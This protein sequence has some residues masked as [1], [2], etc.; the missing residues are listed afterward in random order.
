MRVPGSEADAFDRERAPG[1][2]PWG[3]TLI[4]INCEHV[5]SIYVRQ[6]TTCC[7]ANLQVSG[8]TFPQHFLKI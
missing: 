1:V 8:G 5:R 2:R 3:V 7:H 4:R 6:W